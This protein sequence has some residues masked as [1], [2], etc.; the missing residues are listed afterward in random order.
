[1]KQ[2][3]ALDF[4]Q[5]IRRDLFGN[6]RLIGDHRR[7]VRRVPADV[8]RDAERRLADCKNLLAAA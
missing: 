2:N 4:E 1:M 3:A 7:G 5:Q 8:L 6:L